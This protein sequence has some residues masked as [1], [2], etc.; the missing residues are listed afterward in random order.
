MNK[1]ITL[2]TGLIISLNVFSSEQPDHSIWDRLLQEYV[3]STGKVNYKQIKLHTDSLDAYL[4]E[5]IEHGP[6]ADWTKTQRKAYYINGYNAYC[7]KFV[8]LKYPVA[9]VNDCIF[10]SKEIWDFKM[11]KLGET[12]ITLRYLENEILR[13]MGDPRIHFGIN[14]ASVSCPKLINRAYTSDNLS[15]LLDN[16][17]T[18]FINDPTKNVITAKKMQL[19]KIFEWYRA[20]FETDGQTLVDYINKYSKVKAEANAKIEF[21]DYNWALNE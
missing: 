13:V 17:A 2:L 4:K 16:M 12:T 5:L 18:G 9:S 3:S 15:N 19:S 20:D 1:V 6:Q 7:I 10:S 11:V 21:L 14:C 8:L